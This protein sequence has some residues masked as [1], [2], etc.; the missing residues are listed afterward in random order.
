MFGFEE[1]LFMK[2]F[3]GVYL[4]IGATSPAT[5]QGIVPCAYLPLP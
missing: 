2:N 4:F 1:K 5:A 3:L